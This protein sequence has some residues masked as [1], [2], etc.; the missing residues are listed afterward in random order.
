MKRK[1]RDRNEDDEKDTPP[2]ILDSLPLDLKLAT[3]SKLPAK[4]LTKT[5]SS[6]IRS[7]EFIDYYYAMSSTKPRFIVALTNGVDSKPEEKLTFFYSFSLGGEEESSSLVPKFEMAIPTRLRGQAYFASLHGFLSVETDCG[8]IVCNPSTEQLVTMPKSAAFVGYDPIGGQYKALT[9]Y[10]PQGD[11]PSH[12]VLTLGGTQGWRH[13]E[14]NPEPYTQI[15]YA[16][17]CINGVLYYGALT[18][19]KYN[20]VMSI[21]IDYNGKLASIARDPFYELRSFDLWILED[22]GKNDWSKQTCVLP[23]SMLAPPGAEVVEYSFPGAT[24]A[25]EI[26]I[27]PNK[28]SKKVEPFYIFY[29]NVKTQKERRVR[30]LGIGDNKEFRRSYGLYKKIDCYVR[31]VPQHVESIAFLK[32]PMI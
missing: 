14:G 2:S 4:S 10:R 26:I 13:I 15:V 22:V 5:W 19:H 20:P 31:M 28:L 8:M 6:I 23:Q 30:L 3:L 21:F 1:E 12:K 7:R 29:Y 25:G 17:V 24:K 32:N 11:P 27:L 18:K 9:V 16:G